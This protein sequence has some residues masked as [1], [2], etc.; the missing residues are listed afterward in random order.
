MEKEVKK[1]VTKVYEDIF[2]LNVVLP[3][4]VEGYKCLCNK[5]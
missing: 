1:L 4:A 3:I 5:R 2:M